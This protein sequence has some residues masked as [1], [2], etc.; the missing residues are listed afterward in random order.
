M[1]SHENW[2]D[3]LMP[4]LDSVRVSVGESVWSGCQPSDGDID[5]ESAEGPILVRSISGG[6]SLHH[7]RTL[8]ACAEYV[9]DLLLVADLLTHR[10][11]WSIEAPLLRAIQPSSFPRA[12]VAL[13]L[14]ARWK[15]EWRTDTGPLVHTSGESGRGVEAHWGRGRQ[16]GTHAWRLCKQGT[17][18]L[19]AACHE[20]ARPHRQIKT[21][22]ALMQE[23]RYTVRVT[24]DGY[25]DYWMLDP[26]HSPA[27]LRLGTERV[28][29]GQGWGFVRLEHGRETTY[30][31]LRK[32]WGKP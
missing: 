8:A 9:L 30:G 11:E 16:R 13:P 31:A 15:V 2:W 20:P 12:G 26:A 18:V 10:V 17:Q 29:V 23:G 21:T 4:W 27:P 22:S 19:F 25:F 1:T 7:R 3:T 5:M 32:D 14:E 6:D 24:G 28:E